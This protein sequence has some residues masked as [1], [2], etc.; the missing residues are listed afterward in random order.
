MSMPN[1]SRPAANGC[2]FTDI[3]APRDKISRGFITVLPYSTQ[4]SGHSLYRTISPQTHTSRT[5][6][7]PTAVVGVGYFYFRLSVPFSHDN[8]KPIQLGSPKMFYDESWKFGYV[9]M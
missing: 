9:G 2:C 8:S 4:V 7:T 5:L 3:I 6:V 1:P